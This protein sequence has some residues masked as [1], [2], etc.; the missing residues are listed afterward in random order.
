MHRLLPGV[1]LTLLDLDLPVRLPEHALLPSLL[2]HRHQLV[3][4]RGRSDGHDRKGCVV[5]VEI[6]VERVRHL[7]RK[8]STQPRVSQLS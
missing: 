5:R 3:G 8:R 2:D 6:Q 4:Q 7:S 1:G